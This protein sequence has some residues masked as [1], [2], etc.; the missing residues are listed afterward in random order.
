MTRGLPR[1]EPTR[2]RARRSQYEKSKDV[3]GEGAFGKVYKGKRKNDG[4]FV[5][6]KT[7]KK[8]GINLKLIKNEIHI[9]ARMHHPHLLRLLEPRACHE[10]ELNRMRLYAHDVCHKTL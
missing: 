2:S 3:L 1:P 5:A 8:E 6:I 7:V 4:I 9:W 10:Y